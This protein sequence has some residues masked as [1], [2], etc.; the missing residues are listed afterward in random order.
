MSDIFSEDPQFRR[1]QYTKLS[2]NVQD[3]SQEI[4]MLL[5][6]KLPADLG[7]GVEI[8]F[9]KVDDE[10]GY[11][12]G[13]GIATDPRTKQSIGVPIVVKSWHVAPFDMFFREG[14]LG[15]LTEENIAEAFQQ[16][17]VGV[18]LAP[19]RPIPNMADDSMMDTRVPPLGGKYSYSSPI[20][21]FELLDG[22]FGADDIA[23]FKAAAGTDEALTKFAQR[24]NF[25]LLLKW[26][27]AKPKETVQSK[28]DKARALASL[29]VKKD[30]PNRYRAW[31]SDDRVFEPCL[32]TPDRAGLLSMLET[33][34][35]EFAE[36]PDLLTNLDRYGEFHVT[37]PETPYGKPVETG[38]KTKLGDHRNPFVF[39]PLAIDQS[40]QT[41]DKVG[42]WA[43]RDKAGV[44]SRGVVIPNVVT[45]DGSK[46]G[47]KLFVGKTNSSMQARLAG[48][49]VEDD[50]TV[51]LVPTSP[52]P[53]KTGTLVYQEGDTMF[54]T[55]PFEVTAVS[56]FGSMRSL[57]CI[58]YKGEKLTLVVSPT[59]DGIVKI[60]KSKA[61][62]PLQGPGKNYF[63][64]A[65]LAFVALPRLGQMS[66]SADDFKKT[67]AARLDPNPLRVSHSNGSYLFRGGPATKLANQSLFRAETLSRPEAAFLLGAWGLGQDKIAEALEAA[68]TKVQLEV[69]FLRVPDAVK[70]ASMSGVGSFLRSIKPS[71]VEV[72]KIASALDEA[73]AVDTVLGLGFINSE[74]IDR[75]VAARS[76]MDDVSSM[77][78]KL[79][80]GARLGMRDIP[81]ESARAALGHIQ[82]I[83]DG[84][85]KLKMLG[86][87]QKTAAK[88][89]VE[90]R[91]STPEDFLR[92]LA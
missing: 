78:C 69:H 66:A 47:M 41:I 42:R 63:V 88:K 14:K 53:G 64:S 65:R 76:M 45:F 87:H 9:Q 40:V 43:V 24:K 72:V 25:G 23:A 28:A 57:N 32:V 90:V 13:T 91:V 17:S 16:S 73:E 27:E 35:A 30:A 55:V 67:A 21:M 3:W 60:E 6:Q 10:K 52:D 12:V 75:F 20:Q 33:R 31:A 59:I 58:D 22:T 86:A 38:S 36:P 4:S 61:M 50:P 37:A 39:D 92:A 70:T 79:L 77:I 46:V 34:R 49:S 62:G 56:V 51:K 68:K 44:I 54:A 89:P 84:L 18:G 81:E 85:G 7:L 19:E 26:A 74:N 71:M 29:S 15:P 83:I 2:D 5:A 8:H 1:A 48:I 11:G 80:L 82:K